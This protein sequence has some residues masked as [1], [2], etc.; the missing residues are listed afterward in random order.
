MQRNGSI[1]SLPGSGLLL[2]LYELMKLGVLTKWTLKC[3]Y[4][5]KVISLILILSSCPWDFS[6]FLSCLIETF[7][8]SFQDFCQKHTPKSCKFNVLPK[9]TCGKESCLVPWRAIY[10]RM[11]ERRNI[12][13]NQERRKG[14]PWRNG[15]SSKIGR[16]R[17]KKKIRIRTKYRWY[18][19]TIPEHRW[20]FLLLLNQQ[21]I[22]NAIL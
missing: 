1:K 4:N 19:T 8:H 15:V 5:Q 21:R 6:F 20:F 11:F 22:C 2:P 14:K 18:Y 13:L 17:R 10:W 9:F 12:G 7:F 16:I 3:P